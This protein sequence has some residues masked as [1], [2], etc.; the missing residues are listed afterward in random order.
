[1]IR[2]AP[3]LAL[4]SGLALALG[5]GAAGAELA[6]HPEA[7]RII[8]IGGEITEIV[9]ALGAT[10]LLIGRDTTST[11]PAAVEALPDI[12]YIRAL[13]PEGVLSLDPDLIISAEGAG[14]VEAVEVLRSAGVPF[15]EVPGDASAEGIAEKIAG[16]GQVLGRQA[17]ATALAAK[18]QSGLEEAKILT[19]GVPVE[20]RKTV[21]FILSIQGGRVMAGGRNTEAEAIIEMAGGINAGAGFDGYKQMADEAVIEAAPD[22]L[23]M[24]DREGDL[25]IANAE[26]LA[27]PALAQTPAAERNAIIRMDGMLMLGFGPRTPEA[28][29][30]LHQALYGQEK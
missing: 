17:A 29:T 30:A 15:I 8:S 21:L 25:T 14:P 6:A 13:S 3:A 4:A 9:D 28:V 7:K 18:V 19:A 1:M 24:M 16:V 12:G 27:N 26:A 23:L 10:A 5:A 11:Y 2:L 20:Q 22:V